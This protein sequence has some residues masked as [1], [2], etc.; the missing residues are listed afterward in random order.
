MRSPRWDHILES[1]PIPLIDHLVSEIAKLFAED[2]KQ[3]PPALEEID[4]AT[5]ASVLALLQQD[6][7]RPDAR[8]WVEAFR[9][10]RFDVQ[11]E[12]DAHAEYFRNRRF[13]E[14]G[15]TETDRPMLLFISRYLTEQVLALQEATQ[16]RINRQRMVD[17]LDKTERCLLP[18]VTL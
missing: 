15:L 11:R 16:G 9:L 10:A 5:G 8:V 13:L 4:E 6:P 18:P 1:K 7:Q 14:L 2:L 17:V 12:F 3:W